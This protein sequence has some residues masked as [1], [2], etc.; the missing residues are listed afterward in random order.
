MK[1]FIDSAMADEGTLEKVT[2]KIE[3][4]KLTVA[5]ETILYLIWKKDIK[6]SK[7]EAKE[8]TKY[9]PSLDEFTVDEQTLLRILKKYAE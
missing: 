2:I 6:F 8:A 1:L 3:K 9:F 5:A 4:Q 7:K